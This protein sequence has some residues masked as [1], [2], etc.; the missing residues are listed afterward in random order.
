MNN[1]KARIGVS[2]KNPGSAIGGSVIEDDIFEILK[3][4]V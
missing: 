1:S 3:G 2:L 4:L